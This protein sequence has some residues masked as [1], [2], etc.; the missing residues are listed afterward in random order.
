[1]ISSNRCVNSAMTVP[2]NRRSGV[3]SRNT[4][5]TNS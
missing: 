4:Y 3:P 2:R 5:V 1:V